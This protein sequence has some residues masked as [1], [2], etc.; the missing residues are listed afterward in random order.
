MEPLF[1]SAFILFSARVFLLLRESAPKLTNRALSFHKLAAAGFRPSA[2]T[3][4]K[5]QPR[6]RA[7]LDGSLQDYLHILAEDLH[8]CQRAGAT[9]SDRAGGS[10]ASTKLQEYVE[11][12]TYAV[13]HENGELLAQLITLKHDDEYVDK[14]LADLATSVCASAASRP[15]RFPQSP[16]CSC[17]VTSRSGTWAAS[18]PRFWRHTSMLS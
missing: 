12:A 4:Q 16:C 8:S 11:A 7:V 18:T 10:M 15:K 17:R 5:H 9:G 13:E 14:G 3:F 2:V 6:S 1:T